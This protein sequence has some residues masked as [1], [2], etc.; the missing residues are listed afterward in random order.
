MAVSILGFCFFFQGAHPCAF[1]SLRQVYA[2]CPLFT[3]TKNAVNF[4]EKVEQRLPFCMDGFKVPAER[5]TPDTDCRGRKEE[6]CG[7]L[8]NWTRM[9]FASESSDSQPHLDRISKP[10]EGIPLRVG[11]S[12]NLMQI[13]PGSS[14]N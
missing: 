8:H 14:G 10:R 12:E 13:C 7:F 4:Q 3:W 2:A 6:S 11:S 9:L 5:T 1:V